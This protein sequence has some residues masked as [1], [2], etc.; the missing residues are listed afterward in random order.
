MIVNVFIFSNIQHEAKIS[1]PM[2]AIERNINIKCVISTNSECI[3]LIYTYE[4]E[5]W[6]HWKRTQRSMCTRIIKHADIPSDNNI[7]LY[8]MYALAQLNGA[9]IIK[10]R[11][12]SNPIWYIKKLNKY[13]SLDRFDDQI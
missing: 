7:I 8:T 9:M 2:C 3:R 10:R 12:D 6:K 13:T 11:I 4:I 5:K 1:M